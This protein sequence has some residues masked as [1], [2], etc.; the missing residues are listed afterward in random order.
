MLAIGAVK[1]GR[2]AFLGMAPLS[3]IASIGGVFTGSFALS[4]LSDLIAIAIIRRIFASVTTALSLRHVVGSLTLLVFTAALFMIGPVIVV[5]SLMYWTMQPAM[6]V[7]DLIFVM[8]C[9]L[10]APTFIYLAVPALLLIV[11]LGDRLIWPVLR[12]LLYPLSG[13]SI[14]TNKTAL[15][16]FGTFCFAVA[17]KDLKPSRII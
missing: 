9:V 2:F 13:I 6:L 1:S 7:V 16:S 3:T 15:V 4:I 5:V 12:R 11:V 8:L 14:M 10:N 17:F